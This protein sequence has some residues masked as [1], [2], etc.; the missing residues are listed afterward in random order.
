MFK[1]HRLFFRQFRENFHTTGSIAPSSRW[2]A[3]A[4]ARFVGGDG[5]KNGHPRRVLEVGPGTGAVTHWI[6]PALG[7]QDRFDLV[8]MN[9]QFVAHLRNRFANETT[10]HAVEPRTGASCICPCRSWPPMAAT[11][12][13]FPDCR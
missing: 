11:T 5:S 13:S 8:E 7:T 3:Q 2:L 1:D 9:D 12:R 6:L 4:L 10:W